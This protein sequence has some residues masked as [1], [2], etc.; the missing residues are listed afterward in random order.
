M[1]KNSPSPAELRPKDPRIFLGASSKSTINQSNWHDDRNP[2]RSSIT[3]GWNPSCECRNKDAVQFWD[4][5]CA[6]DNAPSFDPIPCT[7][8]DP[9]SGAGTT[10][11][12]AERLGRKYIGIELNPDYAD[13]GAKRIKAVMMPLFGE[14]I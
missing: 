7:V 13:M 14:V 12:V 2:K 10:G 9:F 4:A 5:P 1:E 6:L 8:L 11:L 3:T